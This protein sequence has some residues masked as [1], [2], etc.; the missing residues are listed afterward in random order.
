MNYVMDFKPI[1]IMLNKVVL[2]KVKL[3]FTGS[4]AIIETFVVTL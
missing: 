2:T 4:V 3:L 1:I